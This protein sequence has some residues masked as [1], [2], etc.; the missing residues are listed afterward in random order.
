MVSSI[1]SRRFPRMLLVLAVC[2]GFACAPPGEEVPP[3]EVS[4]AQQRVV[5]PTVDEL[6]AA[7]YSGIFDR[8]V[9]LHQGRWE[10]EPFDPNEIP[11]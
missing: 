2:V 4:G 9:T 10:G 6:A 3:E 8:P 11:F 1:E 5:A 7:T